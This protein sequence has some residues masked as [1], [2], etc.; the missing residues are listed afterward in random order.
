MTANTARIAIAEPVQWGQVVAAAALRSQSQLI[1][2]KQSRSRDRH[3]EILEAA[4][5]VF[6][7]EGIAQSRISDIAAEAG[8]PLSSVYDYYSSK[9]SIAYVVPISRMREFIVEFQSKAAKRQQA[10]ERLYLFMWLTVDFARRNQD[11]AR[12]LYLEVWPSVTVNKT[13]VKD[14]LDDYARV[15]LALIQ[16]GERTGEWTIDGDLYETFTIF[17]GSLSQLIITWLMY[18]RPRHLMK[19][20]VSIV[21]RLMASQLQLS[22]PSGASVAL[23]ASAVRSANFPRTPSA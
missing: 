14:S 19:A 18:K 21:R 9:E 23:Q 15:M 17:I 16:D 8:V 20:T 5:R 6:A 12:T 2:P 7:R 10:A 1:Q 11:W 13:R 22:L 4:V 3:A